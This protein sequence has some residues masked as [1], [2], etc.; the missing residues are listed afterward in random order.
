[1]SYRTRI[2]LILSSASILV[3]TTEG[4]PYGKGTYSG[5]HK[6]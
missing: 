4:K 2:H 1:V 3:R 5:I 6:Y